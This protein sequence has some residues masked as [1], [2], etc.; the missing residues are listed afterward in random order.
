MIQ[1][2]LLPYQ[3]FETVSKN[4]FLTE[5]PVVPATEMLTR[6]AML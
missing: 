1:T 5:M 6:Y 2:C 4:I 3:L